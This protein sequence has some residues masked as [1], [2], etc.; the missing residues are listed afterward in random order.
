M[1]C[2][3]SL[4]IHFAALQRECVIDSASSLRQAFSPG[5]DR[6]SGS[7]QARAAYVRLFSVLHT[8][9]FPLL[10]RRDLVTDTASSVLQVRSFDTAEMRVCSS[11]ESDAGVN[12]CK[13]SHNLGTGC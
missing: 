3:I 11:D 10:S 5:F 4:S 13:G 2:P 9:T 12:T 6:C 8:A 7:S 1:T